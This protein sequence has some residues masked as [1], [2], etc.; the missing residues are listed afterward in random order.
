LTL[1]PSPLVSFVVSS[2]GPSQDA[3]SQPT[4]AVTFALPHDVADRS[5]TLHRSFAPRRRHDSARSP[6]A[7]GPLHVRRPRTAVNLRAG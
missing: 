7:R 6:P 3:R 5:Y 2:N 4:H 1:L